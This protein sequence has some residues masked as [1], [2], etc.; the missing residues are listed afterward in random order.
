[1]TESQF[2]FLGWTPDAPIPE[3]DKTPV[4]MLSGFLGAGKTSLLRHLLAHS[5][6]KRI[7]LIVNDVGSVNLDADLLRRHFPE[8]GG[9]VG[10]M[11]ELTRGCICCSITNELGDALL[12]LV[13]N[14]KP[15]HIF[16]ESSG[17]AE[18]RNILESLCR[19][20]LAGHHALELVRIF[21][22]VTVVGGPEFL[23]Q[24]SGMRQTRKRRQHIFFQDPRRPLSELMM[25]QVELADVLV[26]NKTDVLK[27]EELEKAV[28]LLR[29]IN[30]RADLFTTVE[31]A[32]ESDFLLETARFS[33]KD[34]Q[35]GSL[36][37]SRLEMLPGQ[38]TP[39]DAHAG[40]GLTAFTYTAR[41]PFRE[42]DFFR[43]LRTE[44]PEVLRAKG[45][46]WVAE[47]PERCGMLSLAGH[48]LRADLMGKWF[49]DFME[50]GEFTEEEMP[51]TV[52]RV[53]DD[54]HGDR[55]QEIVLIGIDLDETAIREKLDACLV[56]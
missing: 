50:A 30:P 44:L 47:H 33:L 15:D 27:P 29:G 48:L 24:W 32:L 17:V 16:V 21:N 43:V 42:R 22:M 35:R 41:K 37:R 34:T 55:R 11:R 9:V 25:E 49:L 38:K 3:A 53:W 51:E 19:R 39:P 46:Y 6:G 13:R 20:N 23:E 2:Q 36:L 12:H 40:F 52:R 26:L 8:G 1:M 4:T 7:G 5:G 28:N 14:V 10:G 56:S 45:F 18:P 31:G 54:T